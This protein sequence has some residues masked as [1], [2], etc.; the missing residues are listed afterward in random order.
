MAQ[1]MDDVSN[2]Q[3][4]EL[5][6]DDSETTRLANDIRQASRELSLCV[7]RM[8][9]NLNS[10]VSTLEKIQETRKEET[11]VEWISGWLKSLL[12]A[13][14]RI[15]VTFGPI[16]IPFLHSIAPESSWVEPAAS[17][18]YVAAQIFCAPTSG[19]FLEHTFPRKKEVIDP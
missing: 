13:L 6:Y 12:E 2:S 17:T 3:F 19:A 1:R 10:F 15:F 11:L 18:L 16:I 8:N 7:T 4:M 9:D 14:A 5:R